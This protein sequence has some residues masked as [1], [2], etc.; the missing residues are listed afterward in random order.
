VGSADVVSGRRAEIT[1]G[2]WIYELKNNTSTM[3]LNPDESREDVQYMICKCRSWFEPQ[4]GLTSA[5]AIS[6]HA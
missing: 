2:K 4:K 3:A 6:R 1:R 5:A